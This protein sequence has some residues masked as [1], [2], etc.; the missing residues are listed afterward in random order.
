MVGEPVEP[1]LV[2]LSNHHPAICCTKSFLC[3]LTS[4]LT[5][6]SVY[7]I[8]LAYYWS[9]GRVVERGGLEN[10]YTLTG[11]GGSNPSRSEKGSA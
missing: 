6:F 7:D 11:I 9:D 1:W 4:L 10:R 3:I 8:V 2:S 5:Q